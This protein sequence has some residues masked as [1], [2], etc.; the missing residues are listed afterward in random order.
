MIEKIHIKNF[1]GIYDTTVELGRLTVLFG[2]PGLGK[3]TVGRALGF[4]SACAGGMTL[5]EASETWCYGRR[6]PF[7]D[8]VGGG[9]ALDL[10]L[11]DVNSPR[12]IEHHLAAYYTG[13]DNPELLVADESLDDG[14]DDGF[15]SSPVEDPIEQSSDEHVLRVRLKR[16]GRYR[17]PGPATDLDRR[18]S[19]LAQRTLLSRKRKES[20]YLCDD[21]VELLQGFQLA[22]HDLNALRERSDEDDGGLDLRGYGLD[23]LLRGFDKLDRS[24][25]EEARRWLRR[26][27]RVDEDPGSLEPTTAPAAALRTLALWAVLRSAETDHIVFIENIER[28]LHPAGIA[29]LL[30]EMQCIMDEVDFQVIATSNSPALI[31]ALQDERKMDEVPDLLDRAVILHRYPGSPG[32][33]A[34]AL[35]DLPGIEDELLTR[36]PSELLSSGWLEDVAIA[37]D[38][39]TKSV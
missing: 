25:R 27:A 21:T 31:D 14:S 3:S 39:R 37:I 34:R 28:D 17:R 7:L 24:Q 32:G 38:P 4:L 10:T 33:H 15:T 29:P 6:D 1:L 18:R 23:G 11:A 12:L 19:A 20:G 2:E 26:I 30:Q 16:G 8:G 5:S 36:K 13:G 9:L 35:G 22:D